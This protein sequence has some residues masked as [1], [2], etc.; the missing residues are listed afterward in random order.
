MRRLKT[1]NVLMTT[2]RSAHL[3]AP[4][5]AGAC[6]RPFNSGPAH[7]A[8]RAAVSCC[9]E[10]AGLTIC[11]AGDGGAGAAC[12]GGD[13]GGGGGEHAPPVQTERG[14]QQLE[15]SRMVHTGPGR[16]ATPCRRPAQGSGC[17][18]QHRAGRAATPCRRPGQGQLTPRRP[19]AAHGQSQSAA[20]SHSTLARLAT[21]HPATHR[22][23]WYCQPRA[24]TVAPQ[25]RRG[26][27]SG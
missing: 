23:G 19:A 17:D 13:G 21:A 25:G 14:S 22:W 26:R 9:G 1:S 10:G 15:V 18:A 4:V 24:R 8:P 16:A 5:E 27:R 20:T 3:K 6:H 2:Q 11:G 7:T 12:G